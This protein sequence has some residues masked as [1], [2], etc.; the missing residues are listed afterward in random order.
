MTAN[1]FTLSW[2]PSTN[3]IWRASNGRNIVSP[4]Y[5]KWK[6]AAG[7]ELAAQRVS[8]F[9]N[10][11]SILIELCPPHHNDY[12]PDNFVKAI[13]DLLVKHSVIAGDSKK[14]VRRLTVEPIDSGLTG[15][16]ITITPWVE[17]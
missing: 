1:S 5:R 2:P 6:E 14:Y 4:P 10:K 16:R 17:D 3:S 9:A 13:L 15:A 11:V 7:W 12:D 8:T